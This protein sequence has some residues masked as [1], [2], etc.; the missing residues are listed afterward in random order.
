VTDKTPL[1]M[2]AAWMLFTWVL[3]SLLT[4]RFRR[5]L[6]RD[7]GASASA[8]LLDLLAHILGPLLVIALTRLIALLQVPWI[9]ELDPLHLA[10]WQIFWTG[11]AAIGL[12]EGLVHIIYRR[13]NRS[14]PLPDL[15]ADIIRAVLVILVGLAVLR[16]E[17]NIDIGPLLASTALVTAVVGF[18]L[19]GV[20]GNLLAGMSMHL[21]RTLQPGVWVE[22]DGIEGKV[23]KTNWRE[24]RLRTLGGRMYIIPNS[25]IAGSK[26]HNFS[27]PTPLRRHEIFVGASYS[28]APDAVIAELVAAARDVPEV[29][30]APAPLA[31]LVEFQ[32]YG[33]NYRLS[34]WTTELQ[35]HVPIAGDVQRNIWYRFKRQGIEI[36]FPMSDQLL[37]DFM[38]VVYNQRKLQPGAD[39]VQA[40]LRD[41]LESD[42][43]TKLFVDKEGQPLLADGDWEAVAPLVK[44]Q[45]YT[46][47][48]RVCRQGEAGNSF[49]VI[50]R[51][52]IHGEVK[53]QEKLVAE[54]DLHEGAVVGEMSLF[55]GVPR[56]ATLKAATG[57]ELLEFGP[58]AMGALLRLHDDLA[59]SLAQLAA[60]RAAANKEALEALAAADQSGDEPVLERQ[61]ILRR[62]WGMVGR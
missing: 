6:K 25:S 23:V 57:L 3:A 19:Q 38:A 50:A 41:L 30:K 53:D 51:G 16:W 48:E 60:D 1:L 32:D 27:E 42:L 17:L 8:L 26:V 45:P 14:F 40:N 39:Q 37:N 21:V 56:S 5:R 54:F 62:L 44:R 55:T 29:R 43:S 47:G 10:A 36:P 59:E 34:F 9:P 4:S 31:F 46:H 58:E 35:R 28:D 12:L 18:A 13:R 20:L 7:N 2:A 52:T 22:V 61:G 11:V 15:L 49:W 33:I 24:T